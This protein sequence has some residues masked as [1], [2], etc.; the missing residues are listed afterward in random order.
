MYTMLLEKPRIKYDHGNECWKY[1]C[2]GCG[3]E[4][5][6]PTWE[7]ARDSALIWKKKCSDFQQVLGDEDRD[8]FGKG[9]VLH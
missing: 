9:E 7:L 4:V 6:R 3:Q 2:P 1:R 8:Y 5:S